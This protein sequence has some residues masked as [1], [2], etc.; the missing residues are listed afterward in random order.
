MFPQDINPGNVYGRNKSFDKSNFESN[1]EMRLKA[2]AALNPS[3][4]NDNIGYQQNAIDQTND[5][6]NGNNN[7]PMQK[8][9]YQTNINSR[10]SLNKLMN[11]NEYDSASRYQTR[12]K[13]KRITLN[14]NNERLNSHRSITV[15]F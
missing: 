8:K 15:K 7:S 2:R 14:S 1:R 6:G 13:S 9:D 4:N 11:P 3:L 5:Y 10:R 12:L